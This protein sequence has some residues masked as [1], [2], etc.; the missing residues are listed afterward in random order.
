MG[1]YNFMLNWVEHEK[2]FNNLGVWLTINF[3]LFAIKKNKRPSFFEM[4]HLNMYSFGV[5]GS[6]VHGLISKKHIHGISSE[7]LLGWNQI[8]GLIWAQR[9]CK[10]YQQTIKRSSVNHLYDEFAGFISR[11]RWATIN[12]QQFMSISI[13][14]PKWICKRVEWCIG[15]YCLV[16]TGEFRTRQAADEKL[17]C[18][19]Y[20]PGS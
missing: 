5:L 19:R 17:S 12:V 6:S 15:R 7:C 18:S 11:C 8:R 10:G 3:L 4:A 2:N 9:L 14:W 1:M 16:L 13:S 20:A